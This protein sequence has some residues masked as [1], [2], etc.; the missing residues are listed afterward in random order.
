MLPAT[1]NSG[2]IR[3]LVAVMEGSTDDEAQARAILYDAA[4]TRTRWL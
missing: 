3:Q 4:V 2:A 1:D